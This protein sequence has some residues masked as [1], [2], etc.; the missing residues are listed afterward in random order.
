MPPAGIP[1]VSRSDPEYH[2]LDPFSKSFFTHSEFSFLSRG[3]KW[4]TV[5]SSLKGPAM[6][7]TGLTA[8]RAATP[9]PA[10]LEEPA[11]VHTLVVA[12]VRRTAAG[13][14]VFLCIG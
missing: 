7:V 2:V 5:S 3:M 1:I 8:D 4:S 10:H 12:A 14:L 13:A 11:A 6:V 9:V